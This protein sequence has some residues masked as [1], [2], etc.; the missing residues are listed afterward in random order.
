MEIKFNVPNFITSVR[1]ALIIPACLLI[2]SGYFD[3]ALLC[4][5]IFFLMDGADGLA[6]KV[7]H[8]STEFGKLFDTISDKLFV[9]AVD[10]CLWPFVP[11]QKTWMIAII[12]ITYREIAV[13]V[14]KLQ[15]RKEGV[16]IGSNRQGKIK[17]AS[18]IA[19]IVVGLAFNMRETKIPI[20]GWL[21][22]STAIIAIL[23]TAESGLNYWQIYNK[24]RIG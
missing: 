20:S 13:T 21:V 22:Q 16:D 19:M 3:W 9:I 8:Q 1:A 17:M 2:A 18:Q 14:M 11:C 10:A 6:A 24:K 7:F 15:K 23:L 4:T 12:F 5:V